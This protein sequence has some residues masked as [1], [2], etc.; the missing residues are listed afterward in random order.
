MQK[1]TDIPSSI[2]W[3]DTHITIL[4]QQALPQITEFID[5]YTIQDVFDSITTL[6]VRGAPAIGIAAA[7]GIA[8]S[9]SAFIGDDLLAFRKKTEED[10]SFLS[11]SRP[12]AVNLFW[13][14]NRMR[15]KLNDASSVN[16]AKTDLTHEAIAIFTEDEATCRSIGEYGLTLF[17]PGDTVLT[18]CNAGGIATAR[19]GTALAPF[20][21][22]AEKGINLRVFACETRPVL[23]GARLTAWELMQAGVDVTLISD[24][25]AAHAIS[26]QKISSIIVGADRITAN[27]DTANKIGTLSLAVLANHFGIPFYVAAPSST[28]DLSLE[29]GDLIPIEERDP[30]EITHIHGVRVAP[31]NVSVFNPAFDVTPNHLITAIITE[32]GIIYPDFKKNIP[33]TIKN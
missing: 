25:M 5:L 31:E 14:L 32:E 8:L 12:T 13:S 30:K 29:T 21:L 4:N 28:F 17:K 22:A 20:H 33:D 16:G 10:I 18:H 26:T 15:K 6:K 23:Q 9:A 1:T 27:G 19:Y 3:K 24:N 11:S 2:Q 7:Y